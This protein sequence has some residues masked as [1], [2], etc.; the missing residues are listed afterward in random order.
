MDQLT[1]VIDA[2]RA[3]PVLGVGIGVAVVV[4]YLL[5]HRKP[6]IQRDADARLSALRRDNPD[7]YNKLRR[8]N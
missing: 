7:Q 6:K 5:L 8:P 1:H 3:N 2:L 4:G